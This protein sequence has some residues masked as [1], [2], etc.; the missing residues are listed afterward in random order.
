LRGAEVLVQRPADDPDACYAFIG[1]ALEFGELMEERLR[2]E[3]REETGCNVV[4]AVYL[5]V[6]EN[7]F[8]FDRAL[9]HSVEHYFRVSLDS[10]DVQS[11]ERQ[12]TQ[13]WLPIGDLTCYDVRPRVVLDAIVSGAWQNVKHLIVPLE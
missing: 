3:Y 12:L 2:Q 6:V 11:S 8:R 4:E 1:G 10:Y 13:H 7:R 9:L 5:F